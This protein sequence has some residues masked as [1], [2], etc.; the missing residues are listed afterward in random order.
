MTPTEKTMNTD[1]TAAVTPT[2]K[3]MNTDTTAAVTPTE[4]TMNTDTTAPAV[5]GSPGM[6]RGRLT[7]KNTSTP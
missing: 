5:H 3:T 7:G 4:K 2:E 1:T 6:S